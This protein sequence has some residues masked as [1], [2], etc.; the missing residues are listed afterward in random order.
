MNGKERYEN[1]SKYEPVV[2]NLEE[3]YRSDHLSFQRGIIGHETIEA[4]G[5]AF[6]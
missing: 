4:G 5:F 3:P 2:G 1:V 6:D